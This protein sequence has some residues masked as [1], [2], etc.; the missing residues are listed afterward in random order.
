MLA[1]AWPMVAIQ[2]LQVAYNIADTFWLG[3]LSADAVGALSLAFPIIFLLISVAGGFT[4][5][6]TILVAQY[7]GADND[8]K[9]GHIAGQTLS[10][11]TIVATVIALAGFFLTRQMLGLIPADEATAA[12]IVPLAG[13]YMELFFLGMPALAGFFI[14]TSLMRGYGNTRTPLV[15]MVVSVVINVVLDPFLIFGWW[16]FPAMGIEGAAIATV[17]SRVVASALGLYVLFGTNVGPEILLP[18]LRPQLDDVRDIVRLGVPSALE[19]SSSSMAMIILTG[20]VATFPPAVVAAYGLGNRLVSLAFLPAMGMGQAIDT[21][22]G[23]N[24]G[25]G[26]PDRAQRASYLSMQLVAVVM[27]VLALVAWVFSEPI[28]GVFLSTDTAQAAATIGHASDYLRIVAVMFV[29]MGVLQVALGTFRGAGNTRTALVFSLVTLWVGRVPATYYLVFVEGWGPT[30]IWIA[31][32][33]GDVIGCIAAVAWLSRG[34][35]KES[36][37]DEGSSGHQPA[38]D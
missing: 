11:V 17:F 20:M 36:I 34:T 27:F 13:D 33:I 31:V 30:G 12:Q 26:K 3:A 23:Q 7:M 21:V 25:A 8:R 38:D 24:L 10:F 6:G 15:V 28:V 22:V 1:L 35:W 37:V 29:F 9:A 5:A 4:T 2:L 16:I 19:Q 32:A 14:F 18:D